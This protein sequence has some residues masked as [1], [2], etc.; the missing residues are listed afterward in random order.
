MSWPW[1]QLGLSGPSDL[2]QVRHAYAEK[3]K[4]THPEEDPEGFQ[5]LHSAYQLASCM[6]RQQK[7]RGTTPSAAPTERRSQ[8]RLVER[9]GQPTQ[10]QDITH[11]PQKRDEGEIDFDRLFQEGSEVSRPRQEERE[12][13]FDFDQLLPEEKVPPRPPEEVQ[14]DFDFDRLFAEGE[15]ERVEARRRRGRERRNIYE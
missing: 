4:S 10:E 13:D 12:Q 15:A 14:Q 11:P 1:S 6:A 3:L 7:R 9:L 5:R 2:S 8:D